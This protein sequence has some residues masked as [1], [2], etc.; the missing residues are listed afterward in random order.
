M[1]NRPL[2]AYFRLFGMAAI[3]FG[4]LVPVLIGRALL[5]K[6]VWWAVRR[7]QMIARDLMRF[8]KIKVTTTGAPRVGNFL[9]ISNHRSYIDPVPVADLVPFVPIAK[10][11]VGRW[12]LIGWAARMTGIFYVKR[13]DKSSR[14]GTREAAREVLK[15]GGAVLVYPEG[16]TSAVGTTLPFRPGTFGMAADLGVGVVPIA[17]E[18]ANASDAWVGADTF[19]PHF[20]RCFSKPE[21]HVWL[22]FFPPIFEADASILLETTQR[23]IDEQLLIWQNTKRIGK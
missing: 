22:H 7:R 8:L 18:Y 9:Y 14:A 21:T 19:I 13:H 10:A 2:L 16:T 20:L 17:I 15:T 6:D 23:L 1:K 5:G 12:P 3:I 4:H 11:E